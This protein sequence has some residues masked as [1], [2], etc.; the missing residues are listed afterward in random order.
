MFFLKKNQNRR[1]L[2]RKLGKEF[3][4]AK[5]FVFARDKIKGTLI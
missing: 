3:T 2:K 5:T 4:I 1:F